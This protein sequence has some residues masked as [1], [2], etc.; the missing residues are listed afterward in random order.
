VTLT[1]D[2]RATSRIVAV[3]LLPGFAKV[4]PCDGVDRW[5][6]NRRPVTVEWAFDGGA[7]VTQ[8][9]RD[10]AEMQELS[11]KRRARSVQ[12]T[13]KAVTAPYLDRDFT[14]ISEIR[15]R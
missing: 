3:G 8:N 10:V 4:D 5:P 13:I 14:A 7:R 11:V 9:L 15:V 12:L 6:Q 1:I 2:L